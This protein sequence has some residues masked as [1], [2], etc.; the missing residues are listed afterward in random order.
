MLITLPISWVRHNS[1]TKKQKVTVAL[2][3]SGQLVITP[4]TTRK[5]DGMFGVDGMSPNVASTTESTPE[6]VGTN[7]PKEAGLKYDS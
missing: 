5:N 7:T 2:D 4:I 6:G 1:L 3:D